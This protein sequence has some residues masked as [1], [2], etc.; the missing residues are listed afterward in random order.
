MFKQAE[1]EAQEIIKRGGSIIESTLTSVKRKDGKMEEWKIAVLESDNRIVKIL[2]RVE[3]LEPA[4][5]RRAHE[6]RD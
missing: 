2:R 1:R 4:S 5:S 3:L 6:S